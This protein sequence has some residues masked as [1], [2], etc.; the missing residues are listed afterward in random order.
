MAKEAGKLYQRLNYEKS[1]FSSGLKKTNRK[2]K[3]FE[4][5]L[6]DAIL[7]EDATLQIRIKE[8]LD[9][10]KSTLINIQ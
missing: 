5:E 1:G 10:L 8:N 9:V 7:K 3:K 6:Y 2:I 4:K